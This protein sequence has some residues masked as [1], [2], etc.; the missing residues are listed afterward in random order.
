MAVKGKGE[1]GRRVLVPHYG[2]DTW[3]KRKKEGALVR[4]SLRLKTVLTNLHQA[5]VLGIPKLVRG[6][7]H[8]VEMV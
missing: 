5:G 7:L 1:G 2:S 3:E 6:I 8:C 4:K